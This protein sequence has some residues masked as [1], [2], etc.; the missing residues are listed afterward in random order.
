[1]LHG[2]IEEII[3]KNRKIK[4]TKIVLLFSGFDC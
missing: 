3:K 4:R 1:M 2:V